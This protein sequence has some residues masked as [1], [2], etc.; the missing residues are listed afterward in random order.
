MRVDRDRV[1]QIVV[2]LLS[3]AIKFTEP[4]GRITTSVETAGDVVLLRVTNTGIG[5]AEDK[6]AD[7]FEPV[8][9]ADATLTRTRSGTG[10][11][12]AIA[13]KLATA[14]GRDLTVESTIGAG[15]TFTLS[16]PRD[17]GQA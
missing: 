5:I 6:L 9:Q 3:N 1:E 11:G 4:G 16:L 10:L 2:N 17:A 8:V 15:T 12:L 7:I 14:M 13:R